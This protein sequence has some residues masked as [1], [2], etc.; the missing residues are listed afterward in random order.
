MGSYISDPPH[1]QL[2]L[3]TPCIPSPELSRIAG[4][5]IYLKLEN[6]QPSGSF[7]SRGIGHLM[8]QAFLKS[9]SSLLGSQPHFY[10]S[11]GGNAGLACA[12]AA[13]TLRQ[14]CDV[15]VT[16]L[17]PSHVVSKLTTLGATAHRVGNSWPEADAACREA[18]KASPCGVYVPP[19]DHPLLWEGHATLV[20]ELATLEKK[21]LL[22]GSGSFDAIV[23]NV[24]GGGLL[25]GVMEGIE[26]NYGIS[27]GLGRRP[28][29]LALE[30]EGT[31]SLAASIKA[32]E[33]VTIPAITSIATSLGAPRVS[34]MT[35]QWAQNCDVPITAP[36]HVGG[37]RGGERTRLV[38]AVV[39]DAEAV[40]ACVKFLDDA[41]MLVEIACGATISSAYKAKSLLRPALAPNLDNESWA[42]LNVVLVVCGGSNIS[43]DMLAVYRAQFQGS[44][45]EDLSVVC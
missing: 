28:V 11:S 2:Y 9:G 17:T 23:C 38:S 30:T 19:F 18:M 8:S 29:V 10:C 14:P 15:F 39:S 31:D 7:K 22:L 13:R 44:H 37:I 16:S 45:M 42:K 26:R 35:Y 24:G 43:T 4:C 12:E 20:D 25:N 3:E 21:G 36:A 6:L 27:R 32:R 1:P 34:E 41:R 40:S 33:H 5:N